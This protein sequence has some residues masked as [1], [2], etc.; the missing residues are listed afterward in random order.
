MKQV[1][2]LLLNAWWTLANTYPVWFFMKGPPKKA[3]FDFMQKE[4]EFSLEKLSRMIVKDI[5]E[6]VEICQDKS[7][8]LSE[9]FFKFKAEANDLW[10]TV[11]DHFTWIIT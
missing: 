5:T 2:D 6:Y 8:S 1:I 3:F 10:H 9:Q 11:N 7:V 4:L